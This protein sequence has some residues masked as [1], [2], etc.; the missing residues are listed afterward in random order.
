MSASM[1]HLCLTL[2]VTFYIVL[3]TEGAGAARRTAA[4]VLTSAGPLLWGCW[5]WPERWGA[6]LGQH[7]ACSMR[8]DARRAQPAS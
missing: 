6:A 5:G 7:E 2:L 3:A 1:F 4:E 8:S